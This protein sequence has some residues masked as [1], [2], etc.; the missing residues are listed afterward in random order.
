MTGSS[1]SGSRHHSAMGSGMSNTISLGSADGLAAQASTSVMHA[2]TG[3]K[4]SISW[5]SSL[6]R[7]CLRASGSS[8]WAGGPSIARR[9]TEDSF[10]LS[11]WTDR[12]QRRKEMKAPAT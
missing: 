4:V 8:I 5:Q 3:G 12:C 1:T 7:N 10:E 11:A 9:T 6:L 2:S